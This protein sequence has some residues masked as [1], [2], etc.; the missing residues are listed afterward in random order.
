MANDIA[1]RSVSP[2]VENSDT[3]TLNDTCDEPVITTD[4]INH[5]GD[6]AN[7]ARPQLNSNTTSE[8]YLDFSSKSTQPN[9]RSDN[10]K[11]SKKGT[12]RA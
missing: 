4:T 11:R 1:Y 6:V 10:A 7:E 5:D 12:S 3:K 9:S 8:Q 2:V